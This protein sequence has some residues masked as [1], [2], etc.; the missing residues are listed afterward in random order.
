MS[1]IQQPLVLKSIEEAIEKALDKIWIAIRSRKWKKA[2]KPLNIISTKLKRAQKEKTTVLGDWKSLV[3][4]TD[5]ICDFL[6]K[7]VIAEAMADQEKEAALL[8]P[9][10][11]NYSKKINHETRVE[12]HLDNIEGVKVNDLF[13]SL[14]RFLVIWY[15]VRSPQAPSCHFIQLIKDETKKRNAAKIHTQKI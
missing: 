1:Q 3:D 10:E 5:Q 15:K 9:Q 7:I 13:P 8:C 4:L 14:R 11:G 2:I 6:I 12:E